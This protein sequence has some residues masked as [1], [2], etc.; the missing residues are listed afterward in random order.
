LVCC[1]KVEGQPCPNRFQIDLQTDLAQLRCLHLD[2]D[3]DLKRTCEIW[4]N[5]LLSTHAQHN[6]WAGAY[7]R[8]SI[9]RCLFR[10]LTFR[11]NLPHMK[12]QQRCHRVD[13]AHYGHCDLVLRTRKESNPNWDYVVPIMPRQP[14][15][16]A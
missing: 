7:T 8:S 6:R 13:I 12:V 11:C 1:G 4:S 3:T 2:H 14:P 9:S 5:S 15:R 16:R 10:Q